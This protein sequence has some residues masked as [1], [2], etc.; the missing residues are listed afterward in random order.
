MPMPQGHESVPADCAIL[1]MFHHGTLE[2]DDPATLHTDHVV[3]MG[4]IGLQF[5]S[6]LSIGGT[7]LRHQSEL[8]KK[9]YRPKDRRSANRRIVLAYHLINLLHPQMAIGLQEALEDLFPLPGQIE[10]AANKMLLKCL[11]DC[12]L[13]PPKLLWGAGMFGKQDNLW[14]RV[15]HGHYRN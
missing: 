7:D 10:A 8:F 3:V 4:T 5:E 1:E 9:L 13:P 12:L 14:N 15:A 6:G 2:F 11:Q